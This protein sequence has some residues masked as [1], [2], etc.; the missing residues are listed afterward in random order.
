[1]APKREQSR[2][3]ASWLICGTHRRSAW[4]MSSEEMR[5]FHTC[6]R[7][8]SMKSGMIGFVVISRKSNCTALAASCLAFTGSRCA[9]LTHFQRFS[10][11]G[12]APCVGSA[13]PPAATAAVS[14]PPVSRS[15]FFRSFSSGVSFFLRWRRAR[16]AS[17]ATGS[18]ALEFIVM[19]SWPC[20]LAAGAAAAASAA[21]S[22]G[23]T[24]SFSLTPKV[25][26]RNANS[27]KKG[28]VR[29]CTTVGSGPMMMVVTTPTV[30]LIM[31]S[32]QKYIADCLN[33]LKRKSI[34]RPLKRVLRKPFLKLMR[35]HA[36]SFA[37]T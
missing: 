25:S 4:P 11:M 9:H 3:C 12:P 17:F 8:S 33:I 34:Q 2:W 24:F 31:P 6:P 19:P 23:S 13:P 32:F 29:R 36:I 5:P 21:V 10:G 1:M 16:A 18:A 22:A 15:L 35:D 28:S 30:K 7:A 26:D 27:L 14:P 37:K 20:V